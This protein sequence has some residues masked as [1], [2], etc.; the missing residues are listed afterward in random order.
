MTE[1][2]SPPSA[3]SRR[4]RLRAHTTTSGMLLAAAAT[5]FGVVHGVNGSLLHAPRWLQGSAAAFAFLLLIAAFTVMRRPRT[6]RSVATLGI[7]GTFGLGLP[8][9]SASPLA[10][11]AAL[12]ATTAALVLLWKV[13]APLLE[14]SRLRRRPV[15]EG[16]A[17]GAAIVAS[18]MWL[19]WLFTGA[20]R[21]LVD[22]F[23]VGWAVVVSGLLSLEWAVRNFTPHRL[24]AGILLGTLGVATAL[25]PVF[26]REWWWMMS[27]FVGSA[28]TATALLRPAP[29]LEMEQTSWWEPLLG[30]PERLLVGT[31]AA[32]CLG[33][34][35][36]LALPQSAATGKSIGF[37]DATF[38]A[39]SAV[40]VTGLIVLD[41]PVDF[42]GFGQLV[43]MLL[44]Q[45]GGVG[46][47]TFSTVALWALGRRMSLQHEGA[48]ASL[49][50]TQ[51]RGRLFATAKRILQLTVAAEGIGAV[52]LAATFIWMGDGLAMALWRGLFT[53]ISAFC[54]AGF[55]LQSDSLIPYQ[56]SPL[57]L[58]TV[59]VLIV[60]GAISPVVAFALPAIVRRSAVPVSAQARLSLSAT[61]VLLLG[62]FFFMLAFEWNDSLRGLGLADKLHNAWFQSVTLRTAGFNSID[63]T[64]VHPAT[65]TL[66]LLWM[67]IGGNPGGTAGGVKTTTISVLVLSVVHA[68][69]G[70]WSLEV[71][72]K[73]VP[74]RTRARAIVV[75]A[76]AAAMGLVALVSIQLTQN[77][78]ARLAVFEVVSALGTVGLSIGGTAEL[79]GI[80]KAVI[81]VCMF[82]GR[83]GGLTLLMFLSSRRAPTTLGRPEEEINVG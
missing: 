45:V 60:L 14:L 27:S 83:I 40:C 5:P 41:T 29:R 36:L 19:L 54:N 22:V 51:D 3:S 71:F 4:S 39:T 66:M 25:V 46:I 65:L 23:V 69:R 34:T 56:H 28:C 77:M 79:D 82:V 48:V 73:R 67:F 2:A 6:G 20:A 11:L 58:H 70:Q 9:L 15:H 72:G 52:V 76:V 74:E 10:A 17:Q 13:G 75:V 53:S 38:T 31:F 7:L 61:V 37:V 49:I 57:V 24:R 42:S 55:A 81:V 78:P 63:L 8:H 1:D 30:H 21:S 44:I 59:G 80:G 33:G 64:L 47:M 16:Q 43:I 68:I 50:S 26:W 12:L 32:L 35:I 18:A 62:G